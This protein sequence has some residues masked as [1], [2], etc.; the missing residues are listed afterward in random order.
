MKQMLLIA[1]VTGLALVLFATPVA[2]QI[3]T[4]PD[5]CFDASVNKAQ[6]FECLADGPGGYG[7]G[8]GTPPPCMSCI[9]GVGDS[10]L[11]QTFCKDSTVYRPEW[12][13]YA[14]CEAWSTFYIGACG[15]PIYETGCSGRQCLRA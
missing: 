9:T 2:A 12:P 15:C 13:Q 1:A 7:P 3:L 10:G 5:P 14:G 6:Y 4:D 11:P 8:G